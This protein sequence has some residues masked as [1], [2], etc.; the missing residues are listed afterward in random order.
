MNAKGSFEVK[1]TAEPPYD[2]VDAVALARA[3]FEKRFSGPLEATSHVQMLSARHGVESSGAYVAVE[4]VT[5]TL[6]GRRGSFVLHHTGLMDRGVQSLVIKVVPDSGTGEL[7]GLRGQM[8]IQ[9][10]E[11]QHFYDFDFELPTA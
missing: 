9:I 2:V 8:G 7:I 1:M 4:R 3:S 5:G 6:L 10:T 11:G